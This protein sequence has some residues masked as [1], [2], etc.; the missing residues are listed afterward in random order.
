M[1][2]FW[3]NIAAYVV[4]GAVAFLIFSGF[5]RIG[6]SVIAVS[7]EPVEDWLEETLDAAPGFV[8]I[9]MVIV[10]IVVLFLIVVISLVLIVINFS[11]L[12]KLS[13]W[14]IATLAGLIQMI[15]GAI[16]RK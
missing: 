6:R 5:I 4:A 16:P 14:I 11:S 13:Y 2:G 9:L 10:G 3:V 8:K 7:A 12:I 1:I 15:A